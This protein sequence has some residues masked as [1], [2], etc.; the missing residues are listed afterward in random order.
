MN[1]PRG[2]RIDDR[3]RLFLSRIYD[4]YRDDFG[5]DDRALLSYLSQHHIRFA[6]A[7]RTYQGRIRYEYDWALNKADSKPAERLSPNAQEIAE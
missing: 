5:E 2:V 3:G 7:L 6:S 4:W 1:H